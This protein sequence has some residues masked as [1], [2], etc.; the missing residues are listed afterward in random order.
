MIVFRQREAQLLLSAT[1]KVDRVDKAI[2]ALPLGGTTPLAAALALAH[3]TLEREIARSKGT[4]PTLILISDGRANVGSR[5]GYESVLGE[6]EAAARRIAEL[7]AARV[8]F[9]DTT[10]AGKDDRRARALEEWLGAERLS[11]AGL[12]RAGRDP[13][14]VARI[15]LREWGSK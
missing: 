7:G 11:L 13:T 15:A 9:L 14:A 3:R 10:E 8:V 2:R 1:R 6:V 12:T 5:A 4:R